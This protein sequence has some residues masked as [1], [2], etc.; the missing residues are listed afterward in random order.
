MSFMAGLTLASPSAERRPAWSP[1]RETWRRY[2]RHKLAVVSAVLLLVLD[3]FIQNAP[4][5]VRAEHA[6]R[7]RNGTAD[8]DRDLEKLRV[9]LGERY[10]RIRDHLPE[11]LDR[12]G[13]MRDPDELKRALASWRLRRTRPITPK[14]LE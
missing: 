11:L 3:L 2:R 8:L 5:D 14:E 6:A 4:A 10:E 12:Y 1:W 7:A 9:L 13:R